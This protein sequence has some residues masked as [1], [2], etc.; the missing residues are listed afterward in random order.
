MIARVICWLRGHQWVT[1]YKTIQ[2]G[3]GGW[4]VTK[5]CKRCMQREAP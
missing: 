3:W 4:Y 5:R 2:H 1:S